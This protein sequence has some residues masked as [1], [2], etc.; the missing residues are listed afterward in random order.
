MSELARQCS[1]TADQLVEKS[2]SLKII[3]PHKKGQAILETVKIL[4]EKGEIQEI[5]KRLDSYRAALD[6][7]SDQPKVL[8]TRELPSSAFDWKLVRTNP[9]R[10]RRNLDLASLQHGKEFLSLE[11]KVQRLID[12][13]SQGPNSFEELKDLIQNNSE[14]TREHISNKFQEHE[15]PLAE[16]EHRTQLL[17]SL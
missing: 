16:E 5:Q 11:Q 13:L 17:E 12:S 4:W 2:H 9:D 7:D 14:K 8:M 10:N 1:A 3:G 6:T 15:R